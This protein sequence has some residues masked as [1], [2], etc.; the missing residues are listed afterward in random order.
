MSAGGTGHRLRV[1]AAEARRAVAPRG[2]PPPTPVPAVNPGS[3]SRVKLLAASG[4]ALVTGGLLAVMAIVAVVVAAN[5]RGDDPPRRLTAV[6][7]PTAT[8][9]ASI[10]SGALSLVA[11]EVEGSAGLFSRWNG[12]A[13]P[14]RRVAG[15]RLLLATNAHVATGDHLGEVRVDVRFPSGETRRVEAIAIA[16][17]ANIDLALLVVDGTGLSPGV[18]YRCIEADGDADWDGLAPGV[19]VVAVGSAQGLSQTHTFGKVSALRRGDVVGPFGCRVVQFDATVRP[20]NSGGPLLRKT[21]EG[22]RWVGIV[23]AVRPDGIGIAIH[24]S[25]LARVDF[26]WLVGDPPEDPSFEARDQP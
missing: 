20:G 1:S 3:S 24:A 6:R 12:T 13:V 23:S 21:P 4:A 10:Q 26:R 18:D 22:W 11:P 25:E 17:G 5:H 7:V 19:D 14:W 2:V 9:D 8:E 16:H 15:G